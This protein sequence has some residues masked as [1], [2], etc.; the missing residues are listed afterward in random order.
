[1][2]QRGSFGGEGVAWDVEPERC[3]LVGIVFLGAIVVTDGSKSKKKKMA[4]KKHRRRWGA[5][6]RVEGKNSHLSYLKRPEY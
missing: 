5:Q 2:K 6:K 1:M 3:H 4:H